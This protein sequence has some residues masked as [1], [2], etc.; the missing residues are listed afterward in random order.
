MLEQFNVFIERKA[1][2]FTLVPQLDMKSYKEHLNRLNEFVKDYEDKYK[3]ILKQE[4]EVESKQFESSQN[5]TTKIET[6]NAFKKLGKG[7]DDWLEDQKFAAQ[8]ELFFIIIDLILSICIAVIQPGSVRNIIETIKKVLESVHNMD[9]KGSK[10]LVN[11]TKDDDVK[12]D[13]DLK[14]K[15]EEIKKIIYG[16]KASY[17]KADEL[18]NSINKMNKN[19]EDFIPENLNERLET[20]PKGTYLI[21]D[22]ENIKKNIDELHESIKPIEQNIKGT[23]E[24]FRSSAELMEFIDVYIKAKIEE[25]KES[26]K[27]SQIQK[28]LEISNR[29]KERLEQRI[30]SNIKLQNDEIKLILFERLIN[31]KYDMTLFMEKY[32]YA[33]EYR[34][35]SES[36]L[37]LSVIQEFNE[38]NI[39][40]MFKDLD[41]VSNNRPQIKWTVIEFKEKNVIDEFIKNKSVKISIPSNY[42]ELKDYARLRLRAFRVYLKGVGTTND[43]ITLYINHSD[44]FYDRDEKKQIHHFKSKDKKREFEYIVY[45]KYFPHLNIDKTYVKSDIIYYDE[46]DKDYHFTPTLFSQ[47]EISLKTD[48]NL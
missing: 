23:E 38:N 14:S 39:N 45:E 12:N 22:W 44:D 31:I 7:I 18:R 32:Q 42:N 48:T 3:D 29:I 15:A 4:Q 33:Y 40:R 20:D 41:E 13:L 24:Y 10:D 30:E 47:W 1:S 9:I 11:I 2:K 6:V 27:L 43:R 36:N 28:Q 21:Y 25:N 37:K 8:K 5:V 35:L 19:L 34:Y 26:K 46:A 17:N 16:L